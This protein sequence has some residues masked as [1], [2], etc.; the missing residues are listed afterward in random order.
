[1]VAPSGP[2]IVPLNYALIDGTIVLRTSPYSELAQHGIGKAAAFEID[3][4]DHT[5]Q[6]GW[7]VVV[8]GTLEEV[9]PADLESLR[10]AWGPQPWAGGQRNLYL[11]LRWR[12]ISGRRLFGS[13][14]PVAPNRRVL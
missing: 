6:T 10:T 3:E 12:E 11:R 8:A 4:V 14:I 13:P 7:S 1:V 9:E 2:R 5:R